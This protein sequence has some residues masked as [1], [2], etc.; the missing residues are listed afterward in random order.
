MVTRLSWKAAPPAGP[1]VS[2]PVRVLMPLL[3]VMRAALGDR[4]MP[5]DPGVLWN[6]AVLVL[7]SHVTYALYRTRRWGPFVAR[8]AE[9]VR[10]DRWPISAPPPGDQTP[11]A[12]SSGDSPSVSRS[13]RI[14][15]R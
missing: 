5:K 1:G 13:A 11:T 14:S 15:S 7:R 9:R 6:L 4:K 12:V 8:L 10:L 2:A 3:P